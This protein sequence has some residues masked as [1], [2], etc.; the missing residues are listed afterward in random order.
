MVKCIIGIVQVSCD[1]KFTGC[2]EKKTFEMLDF[3]YSLTLPLAPAPFDD[4][5]NILAPKSGP[6]LLL[7]EVKPA[8]VVVRVQSD[9][10]TTFSHFLLKL[11]FST[12]I[13]ALNFLPVYDAN[14]LRLSMI[15]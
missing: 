7:G 13:P 11:F 1:F 5:S 8:L 15:N 4:L 9:T 2:E 6:N 10:K 3:P 12:K 14:M